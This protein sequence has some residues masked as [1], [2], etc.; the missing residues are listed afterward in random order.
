M[1]QLGAVMLFLCLL[2]MAFT[3]SANQVEDGRYLDPEVI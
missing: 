1:K 2:K 3:A